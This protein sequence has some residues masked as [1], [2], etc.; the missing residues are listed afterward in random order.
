LSLIAQAY[1]QVQVDRFYN[2]SGV[3]VLGPVISQFALS[4]GGL[5]Q[6]RFTISSAGYQQKIRRGTLLGVELLVREG[7][8]GFAYVKQRPAQPGGI[9]LLEDRRKDRYRAATFSAR[10]EFSESAELY[11]AY[12]W[13]RATTNQ[14][15]T[16]ALGSIFYAGQRSG[17]VAWDT[18][19]RLVTWG[20]APM[21]IWGLQFSY[22]FEYR[23]GYPFSLVN[24]QQQLIGA[25]IRRFP[26]YASLNLGVEKKFA[27]RG[28]LWAARF[29]VVDALGRDNFDAVVNNIDAP[30]FGAFAGGQS[31]SYTGRVRFVGRK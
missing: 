10:H 19:H 23:T 5:Q 22:F 11:G 3:Q 8:H 16:P 9:L 31:R 21:H 4:G 12:T 13:S 30:N 15:L 28:Y 27:F 20:W 17:R 2:R 26:P 6:P 7:Y 24:F 1:D 25:N 14:V 18:P 29:M